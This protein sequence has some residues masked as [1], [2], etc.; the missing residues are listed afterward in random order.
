MLSRTHGVSIFIDYCPAAAIQGKV[1]EK[2]RDIG[3]IAE[4]G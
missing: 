1:E 2:E 4:R 3:L